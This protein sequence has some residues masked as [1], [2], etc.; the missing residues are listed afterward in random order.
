MYNLQLFSIQAITTVTQ[1]THT[2][3]QLTTPLHPNKLHPDTN[4]IETHLQLPTLLHPSKPRCVIIETR[5]Q[6][7]TL[8]HPSKPH[9]TQ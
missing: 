7:A 1:W 8:I 3:V 5:V 4:T 2:D 6:L 9:K